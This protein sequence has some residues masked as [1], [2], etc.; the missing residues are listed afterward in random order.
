MNRARILRR[1][2]RFALGAATVLALGVAAATAL[3]AVV[4]GVVLQPLPY[5]HPG[6]LVVLVEDGTAPAA[7]DWPTSVGRLEDFSAAGVFEG[8]LAAGRGQ[9]LALPGPQG[10]E[11]LVGTRVTGNL[12]AV[13]GVSAQVGRALVPSDARPGAAPVAVLSDG[14]WRR[15]FAADPGIVGRT[16]AFDGQPRTVVGIAPAGF[17]WPRPDADVWVPFV[18]TESERNRAWFALRTVGRL[19]PFVT[20]EAAQERLRA[21]ARRLDDLHPDTERGTRPRL[22]P[23]LDDVLGPARGA[24]ELLQAA[25][26]LLLLIAAANLANLLVARGAA[27]EGELAVRAALGAGRFDLLALLLGEGLRIG[28]AAALLGVPLGALGLHAALAWSAGAL[29]RAAEVRFDAATAAGGVAMA[30]GAALLASLVAAGTTLMRPRSG[31]VRSTGK[32]TSLGRRRSLLAALVVVEVSAAT[33]LAA[34]SGLLLRS[35]DHVLRTE[36]GFDPRGVVTLEVAQPPG[37]DLV[38]SAAYYRRLLER[39]RQLPGVREVSGLSRLPVVGAAASTGYELEGRPNP[40]GQAPVAD[41]RYVEPGA[42]P[43]LRVPFVAGRDVAPTDTAEATRV[44]LVNQAFVRAQLPRGDALGKRFWIGNERGEW[45]TIVGVVGDVHLAEL[46]RPVQPTIWMPL[47]QATFPGSMRSLAV[48]ARSP[49]PPQ[50]ALERLREGIAAFDALQAPARPRTV[51]EA[52]AGS[53]AARRLHTG[54][55]LALAAVAALLAAAGVYAVVNYSVLTRV[56]EFGVRLALGSRRG[57]L[58]RLVV[59][60]A[61]RLGAGGAILGA[62]LAVAGNRLVAAALVETRPWDPRVLAGVVTAA[63]GAALVAS[64][65]PAV[66]AALTSPQRALRGSG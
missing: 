47:P 58:V 46:E 8:G 50:L 15:R 11:R 18:A 48:V 19:A 64:L 33:A 40:P 53:L 28:I 37:A 24:L 61:L 63:L 54:I 38:A 21:V 45:R 16:L 39:L 25:V 51:E 10:A 59:G 2:P 55:F 66:R 6:R 56:D 65:V 44:V 27:R 17:S 13:L 49:L 30:L 12:F 35:L 14:L 23:L 57:S 29:P 9:D 42:L 22:V 4:R 60:Q 5:L 1:D 62:G 7:V 20:R 34:G 26:L 3:L 36:P 32:G 52:L 31:A 41:L 43:L